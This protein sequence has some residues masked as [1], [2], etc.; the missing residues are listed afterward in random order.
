MSKV[1]K[2]GI[3]DPRKPKTNPNPNGRLPNPF[4]NPYTSKPNTSAQPWDAYTPWRDISGSG[5]KS[6]LDDLV[7]SAFGGTQAAGGLTKNGI[8]SFLNFLSAYSSVGG[9]SD[10][11]T[12]S[13]FQYILQL[14]STSDQRLYDQ[15]MTENQRNYDWNLKQEQRIYDD[16]TNQL[17][18]LMGAGIS[19]DAA[20]QILSGSAGNVGAGGSGSMP[21]GSG[22]G[23]PNSQLPAPS[24]TMQNQRINNALNAINAVSQLVQSGGKLAESIE[25]VQALQYSNSMTA[26]QVQSLDDV[27]KSIQQIQA[28]QMSGVLKEDDLKQ[29]SNFDDLSDYLNKSAA[30]NTQVADF[31]KSPSYQRARGSLFGLQYFNRYWQNVRDNRDA[32]T[33]LDQFIR[34]NDLQNALTSVSVDKCG[35][36][37]SLIGTQQKATEQSIIESC[38]R[39]AQIDADIEVLNEQGEWLRVQEDST[40]RLTDSQ[41]NALDTQTY[42]QNYQND[43]LRQN[44]ELN[45]AGFPMMKLA[46]VHELELTLAKM[47]CYTSPESLKQ[48]QIKWLQDPKNAADVAYLQMIHNNAVGDFAQMYPNIYALSVGC[49]A[50]GL[51]DLVRT[52]SSTTNVVTTLFKAFPK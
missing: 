21:F 40:R 12:D 33:R 46:R 16:P 11:R 47:Q 19:R 29:L 30:D 45:E 24:G 26:Q 17:S 35:A 15:H 20:L 37:M 5:S 22:V 50:S 41:V 7:G 4:S 42:G 43:M 25:Q 34:Q 6:L 28:L 27:Q 2:G 38:H 31:I 32:G 3:F 48:F 9:T 52:G 36:E 13:L 49:Q 18:R 1:K 23:A 39:V 8:E 10:E 14:L 51:N 44:Y